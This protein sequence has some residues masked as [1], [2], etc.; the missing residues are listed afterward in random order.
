ML[1]IVTLTN[2]CFNLDYKKLSQKEEEDKVKTILQ[3]VYSFLNYE[4]IDGEKTIPKFWAIIIIL[5][6]LSGLT[7]LGNYL[8]NQY[9][10]NHPLGPSRVERDF[11]KVVTEIQEEPDSASARLKLAW[12]FYQQGNL[13]AAEKHYREALLIDGQSFGANLNLG[14]IRF[15]QKKYEEAIIYFKKAVEIRPKYETTYFYLGVSYYNIQKFED[16][17]KYLLIAIKLEPAS[18]D[19]HYYF[20]LTQENLGK[21]KEAKE[22]LAIALTFD[23]Q[24]REAQKALDRLE[25]KGKSK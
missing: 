25:G 13:A 24:Y 23:P 14:V 2:H 16:A 11:K 18:A 19:N 4:V 15:D 7:Y 5:I 8:G 17:L 6:F 1:F 20:A 9:F 3:K 10:W 12:V 21:L 22:H